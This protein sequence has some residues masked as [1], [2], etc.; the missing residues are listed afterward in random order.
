MILGLK[1]VVSSSFGSFQWSGSLLGDNLLVE[2]SDLQPDYGLE[3]AGSVVAAREIGVLQHLLGDLPVEL[4]GE[5]AQVALDVDELVQ[6][7][8]LPIHLQN[9]D[10][11]ITNGS[12]TLV[13]TRSSVFNW[14]L[15]GYVVDRCQ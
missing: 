15:Q 5:V 6:S 13:K 11:V 8:E 14:G 12:A 7:V 2:V 3:E 4:C 10:L 9:R 1:S